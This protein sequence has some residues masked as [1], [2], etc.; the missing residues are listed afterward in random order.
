MQGQCM[1]VH[2]CQTIIRAR[3]T[4]IQKMNIKN[5]NYLEPP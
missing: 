2:A 1:C 4:Y 3:A 5:T